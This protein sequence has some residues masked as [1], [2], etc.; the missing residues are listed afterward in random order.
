MI[1]PRGVA[2]PTELAKQLQAIGPLPA[3]VA[4]FRYSL[5][6]DWTGDPAIFFWVTLTDEAARRE[7]LHQNTQS[8]SAFVIDRLDPYNQWGLLPYFRFRSQSEQARLQDP[9][10]G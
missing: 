5:G 6:N 3:G 1:L 8:I 9:V 10:F 4:N 7:I 2:Q